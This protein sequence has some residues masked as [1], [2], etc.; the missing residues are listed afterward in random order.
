MATSPAG[1]S[2]PTCRHYRRPLGAACSA[3]CDFSEHEP[4]T[5]IA[6]V[7]AFRTWLAATCAHLATHARAGAPAVRDCPCCRDLLAYAAAG[8]AHYGD[9]AW[10]GA[11]APPRADP[12]RGRLVTLLD[13]LGVLPPLGRRP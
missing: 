4:V 2:C 3:C 12:A 11:L 10:F 7:D 8:R 9:A 13:A 1:A 5:P 6:A